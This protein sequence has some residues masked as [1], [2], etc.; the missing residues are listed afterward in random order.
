MDNIQQ[1]IPAQAY[2]EPNSVFRNL[3]NGKFQD[4]SS[5]AGPSF[6]IPAPIAA[7]P[8]ATSS[9]PAASMPSSPVSMSPSN[10]SVTPAQSGH[11]WLLL[12]LVGTRSNRMGLGA[13]IRI[14][15]G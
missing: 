3:G 11:H 6:Q 1:A 7:R 4:V 5:S 10:F 8:L 15:T 13:Q 14:T 12:R 9:T 2:P